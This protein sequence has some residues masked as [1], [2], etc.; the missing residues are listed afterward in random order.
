LVRKIISLKID[1]MITVQGVIV[2]HL[3]WGYAVRPSVKR[4]EDGAGG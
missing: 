2:N 3:V 4:G 1:F